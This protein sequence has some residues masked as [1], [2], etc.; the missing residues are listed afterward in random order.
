MGLMNLFGLFGKKAAKQE[1]QQERHDGAGEPAVQPPL[2]STKAAAVNPARLMRRTS[3]RERKAGH[4]DASGRWMS[5]FDIHLLYKR[6][7]TLPKI[8]EVFGYQATRWA[9]MGR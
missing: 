6:G 1:R 7:M 5:K 8:R 9:V 2:S 4:A 3:C